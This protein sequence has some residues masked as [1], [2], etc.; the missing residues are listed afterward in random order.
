VEQIELRGVTKSFSKGKDKVVA[1]TNINLVIPR[2]SFLSITGESGSGKST[3]MRMIA[4]I[5]KPTAGTIWVNRSDLWDLN[6]FKR[7]KFC[8]TTFAQM[9]RQIDARRYKTA[10][11]MVMRVLPRSVD[12]DEKRKRAMAMLDRVGLAARAKNLPSKLSGGE[13]R[14]VALARALVT[15]RPI[16]LAEEPTGQVDPAT[17]RELLALIRDINGTTGTTFVVVTDSE[18]IAREATRTI[19]LEEGRIAYDHNRTFSAFT[20]PS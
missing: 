11:D 15:E 4:G 20:R 8:R 5:D 6:Y 19:R 13:L 17:A 12:K 9:H 10:V 1:V 3:L 7:R 2:G 18:P 14:R 16:V